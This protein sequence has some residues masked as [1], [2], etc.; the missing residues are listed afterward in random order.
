MYRWNEDETT[1]RYKINKDEKE[2]K[3]FDY[4]IIENIYKNS[5]NFLLI[6]YNYK[7]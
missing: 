3:I 6:F 5:I 1:I 2:I 4:Q 7:F